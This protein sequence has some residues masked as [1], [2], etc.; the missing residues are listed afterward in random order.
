MTYLHYDLQVV[1]PL[2]IENKL[3]L[4][5]CHSMFSGQ[6]VSGRS[7]VRIADP[8][9]ITPILACGECLASSTSLSVTSR[10]AKAKAY[11]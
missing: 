1:I 3:R 7:G 8:C 4:V 2:H 6:A 5:Q 9:Y 11:S 10:M